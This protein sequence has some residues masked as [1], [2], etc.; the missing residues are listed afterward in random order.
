MNLWSF[1]LLNEWFLFGPETAKQV[2]QW[3][4]DDGGTCRNVEQLAWSGLAALLV[5]LI[6]T[7]KW[8]AEMIPQA[9]HLNAGKYFR[10]VTD[11]H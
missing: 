11:L 10:L 5:H 9:K 3:R 2:A 8:V 4:E 6:T 1:A 7:L